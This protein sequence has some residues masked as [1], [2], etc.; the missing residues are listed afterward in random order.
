[1]KKRE[2]RTLYHQYPD[3]LERALVMEDN[4][5]P[6]LITVKGLGRD[7]AWRTF[8]EFDQVQLAL[9]DAFVTEE[10]PCSCGMEGGDSGCLAPLS[11]PPKQHCS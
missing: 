4:A 7:F 6:N 10:R 9:P 11:L 3:L 8:I 2:I 5:R 1:M